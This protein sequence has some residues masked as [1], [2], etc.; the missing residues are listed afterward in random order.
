MRYFVAIF[1]SS[2]TAGCEHFNPGALLPGICHPY[3][4]NLSSFEAVDVLV[5]LEHHGG[6]VVPRLCP[7]QAYSID[8]SQSRINDRRYSALMHQLRVNSFLGIAATEMTVSGTIRRDPG[9]RDTI[10]VT[11]ILH[12]TLQ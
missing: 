9:G 7:G 12:Y 8:F 4:D 1:L 10:V 3:H 11:R 6:F 5:V 2:L